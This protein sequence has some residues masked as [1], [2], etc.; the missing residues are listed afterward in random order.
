[1]NFWRLDFIC[2]NDLIVSTLGK[3]YFNVNLCTF[4]GSILE[5]YPILAGILIRNLNILVIQSTIR[6]GIIYLQV[7]RAKYIQCEICNIVTYA[8]TKMIRQRVNR[9]GSTC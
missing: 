8:V 3:S 7:L 9:N 4:S 6:K 5:L 1:M 2:D